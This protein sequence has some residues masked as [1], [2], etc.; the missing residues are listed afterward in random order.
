MSQNAGKLRLSPA[1]KGHDPFPVVAARQCSKLIL[2]EASS[3]DRPDWRAAPES[4]SQEI[5]LSPARLRRWRTSPCP[6]PELQKSVLPAHGLTP[7]MPPARSP[8]R[9]RSDV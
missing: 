5:R 6:S 4:G 1:K 3:A 8:L 2:L 7:A 9:A